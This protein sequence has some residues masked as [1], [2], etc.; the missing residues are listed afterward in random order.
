MR[1]IR[2]ALTCLGMPLVVF[3][4]TAIDSPRLAYFAGTGTSRERASRA[5]FAWFTTL[6]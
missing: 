5:F 6:V 3:I 2:S 1:I 4:L